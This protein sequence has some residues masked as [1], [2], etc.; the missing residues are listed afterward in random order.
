MNVITGFAASLKKD[1]CK[2]VVMGL[3]LLF[4]LLLISSVDFN[5]KHFDHLLVFV[6]KKKK[7]KKVNG[8][9]DYPSIF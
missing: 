3:F 6:Y 9:N 8:S 5:V 4:L 7:K 1:E 2:V